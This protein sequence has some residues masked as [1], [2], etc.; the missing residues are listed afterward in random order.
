MGRSRGRRAEG[1]R[2]R[3]EERAG[4]LVL[5]DRRPQRAD[6]HRRHPRPERPPRPYRRPRRAERDARHRRLPRAAD[7]GA[8]RCGHPLGH[9]LVSGPGARSGQR[10]HRHRHADRALRRPRCA[11]RGRRA[12][13]GDGRAISQPPAHRDHLRP[14]LWPRPA[15]GGPALPR[16]LPPWRPDYVDAVK[17]GRD[18]IGVFTVLAEYTPIKD[19]SVYE[20]IVPSGIDPDGELN[21]ESMEY[22]QEWYLARGYLR[23]R[24]DLGRVVDLRYRDAALQRLGRYTP[25]P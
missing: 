11:E 10:G 17:H 25:R 15:R 1:G 24:V 23:E 18:R 16:R 3:V 12:L 14:R 4:L 20:A 2:R 22:D 9:P 7:G 8:E 6:R 5:G 19:L 13:E 21:L